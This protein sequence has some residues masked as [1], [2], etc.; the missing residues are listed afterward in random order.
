MNLYKCSY[1]KHSRRK[2]LEKNSKFYLQARD[3]A[4][5][6]CL[7]SMHEDLGWFLNTA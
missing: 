2:Q 6:Q 7:P 3:V 4:Q 5:L 1:L